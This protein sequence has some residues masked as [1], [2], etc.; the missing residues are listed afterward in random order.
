MIRSA[1]PP[2]DGRIHLKRRH[3]IQ[4]VETK[5]TAKGLVSRFGGQP[6]WLDEPQWPISAQTG[7][8]MRFICQIALDERLFPGYR[9]QMAYLFMTDEED[10]V[11]GTWE[12]EGGENAVILQPGCDP[13]VPVQGLTTGPSLYRMVKKLFTRHLVPKPC[14][15]SVEGT[16][17]DEPDFIPEDQREDWSD[18]VYERYAASLDGN[19]IG[20][21]PL[22]MQPD[23]F[24]QGG[25]WKLLLQLDSTQVPFFVNFGDVGVGYAFLSEDG[26][27]AR[28]LWQCA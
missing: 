7:H 28:F 15:F 24:P 20:G 16:L 13:P 8:P 9:A 25:P 19:K 6:T 26:T 5:Q 10:Y 17:S 11:D 18:A 3:S 12:P 14:T 2:A 21:S 22:F 1:T 27:Q 23:E 4:F